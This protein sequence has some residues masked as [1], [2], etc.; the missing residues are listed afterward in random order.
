VTYSFNEMTRSM[1]GSILGIDRYSG[2][3]RVLG[4]IDYERDP[5]IELTIVAADGG[6]N[7]LTSVTRA[8]IHVIDH[9]DELPTV[10]IYVPSA[11]GLG[12]VT[13]GE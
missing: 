4:V 13:E 3:V 2:V 6:I 7:R 9:N 5:T 8:V 12:H 1:Y 11:S 10:S